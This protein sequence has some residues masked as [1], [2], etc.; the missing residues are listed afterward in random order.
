MKKKK[1]KNEE[2]EDL[3]EPSTPNNGFRMSSCSLSFFNV[4]SSWCL[5]WLIVMMLFL[6]LEEGVD[7]VKD[8][9]FSVKIIK[10]CKKITFHSSLNCLK[11]FCH[12]YCCCCCYYCCCCCWYWMCLLY[13]LH[14][15]CLT[16]DWMCL[17]FSFFSF[18]QNYLCFQFALVK[19]VEENVV[20]AK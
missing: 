8:C 9:V 17:L 7:C 16:R 5:C 3:F 10:Y 15:Y 20:V 4:W 18:Q 2:E 14:C 1:K 19:L 6:S 13:Y 11:H 12:C